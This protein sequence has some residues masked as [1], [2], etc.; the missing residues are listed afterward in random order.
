[1]KCSL[2]SEQNQRVCLC[3]K[4]RGIILMVPKATKKQKTSKSVA[5]TEEPVSKMKENV[6]LGVP[7]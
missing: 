3:I 1:L 4:L 5:L 2:R 7:R 6:Y